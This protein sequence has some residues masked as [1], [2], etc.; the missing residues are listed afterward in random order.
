MHGQQTASDEAPVFVKDRDLRTL[1]LVLVG[2]QGWQFLFHR[3]QM[4]KQVGQ[5]LLMVMDGGWQLAHCRC[6]SISLTMQHGYIG[7]PLRPVTSSLSLFLAVMVAE[8]TS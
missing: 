3:W 2:W 6:W 8:S 1:Q 5:G 7:P 4:I